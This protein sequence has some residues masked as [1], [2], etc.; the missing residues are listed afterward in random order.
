[1]VGSIQFLQPSPSNKIK[2][3]KFREILLLLLRAALL[4]MLA[5]LLAQPVWVVQTPSP[6]PPPLKWL[7]VSP[8]LLNRATD[9][10]FFNTVDSLV[11]AGYQL[12]LFTFGFPRIARLDS[13]SEW[14]SDEN[15]WSLLREV[16]AM[17]PVGSHLWILTPD[18]LAGIR[19]ERPFVSSKLTWQTIP[20]RGQNRW[21]A[22]VRQIHNDGLEIVIGFSDVEQTSY[23]HYLRPIPKEHTL[24]VGDGMPAIEFFLHSNNVEYELRLATPDAV[25]QDN[26]YKFIRQNTNSRL[27]IL[28]DDEHR[29]DA[30]YLRLAV[31]AVLE[32]AGQSIV[33]EFQPVSRKIEIADE[34]RWVFWLSQQPVSEKLLAQL[35]RGMTLVS[36]ANSNQYLQTQSRVVIANHD[37]NEPPYLWRRV[38]AR[39]KG[40]SLWADGFGE[41]ILQYQ[42]KGRG[43]HYQFYSRF[44][45]L[46][47]DLVLSAAFP[48]WIMELLTHDKIATNS[49]PVSNRIS[50]LRRISVDQLMPESKA[51]HELRPSEPVQTNLHLL[52]GMA[53]LFLFI[54]ERWLSERNHGI[55]H[56]TR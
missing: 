11:A 2:S 37:G 51:A 36:S 38:P 19:G 13:L 26:H 14:R 49:E 10:A 23:R 25:P 27:V 31:E 35:E 4:A 5:F 39:G 45:P 12:R 44:H 22:G 29:E 46:W 33:V 41:P 53:A 40:N 47:N 43:G 30:R 17:V 34:T 52:F 15:Y 7:L 3:L 21:I 54:C 56:E 24:L 9:H 50:D 18:R 48:N 6:I 28:H 55:N 20:V 8:D 32:T 42:Q 1:L 16:D